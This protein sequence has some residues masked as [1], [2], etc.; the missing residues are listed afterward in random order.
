[1]FVAMKNT[2]DA[3]KQLSMA[4]AYKIMNSYRSAFAG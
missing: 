3:T 4:E 2:T 1:M